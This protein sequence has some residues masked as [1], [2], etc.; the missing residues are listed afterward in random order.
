MGKKGIEQQRK[1]IKKSHLAFCQNRKP[2]S[3]GTCPP[4]NKSSV[5][6]VGHKQLDRNIK[7]PQIR[8]TYLGSHKKRQMWIKKRKKEDTNNRKS[9]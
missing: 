9:D 4:W 1:S 7:L 3:N 8:N 6:C 5:N 2:G